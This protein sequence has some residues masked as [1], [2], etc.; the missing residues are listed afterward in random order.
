M[1]FYICARPVFT[2]PLYLYQL[3][4]SYNLLK[5][6]YSHFSMY[7]KCHLQPPLLLAPGKINYKPQNPL[8]VEVETSTHI[9]CGFLCLLGF[10]FL[11]HHL[12]PHSDNLHV[13]FSFLFIFQKHMQ[14]PK[15][16]LLHKIFVNIVTLLQLWQSQGWGYTVHYILLSFFSSFLLS[17]F[18]L[19]LQRA[20]GNFKFFF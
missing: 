13:K 12:C 2:C 16:C 8:S 15:P 18:F 17:F 14:I 9:F 11:S 10:C 5:Y 3:S 19:L 4:F 6:F 7:C 20:L 1:K